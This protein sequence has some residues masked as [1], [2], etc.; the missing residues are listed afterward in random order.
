VDG[1]QHSETNWSKFYAARERLINN[2]P[3]NEP[4][5]KQAVLYYVN[6]NKTPVER[7]FEQASHAYSEFN[8]LPKYENMTDQEAADFDR[9]TLELQDK[10]L[11]IKSEKDITELQKLYFERFDLK[12]KL[13]GYTAVTS[14]EREE[15]MST[16]KGRL[17]DT[18]FK[19]QVEKGTIDPKKRKIQP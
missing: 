5:L 11:R 4:E 8:A 13:S 1:V 18:W 9:W 6:K 12:R 7:E 3:D 17:I 14:R 2:L 10:N 19:Q 15:F 16:Y